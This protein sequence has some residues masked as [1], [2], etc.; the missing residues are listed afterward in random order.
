VFPVSLDKRDKSGLMEKVGKE[1]GS[2][3]L[4]SNL[5]FICVKHSL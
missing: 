1:E 2:Y 5:Q 4:I 3:W